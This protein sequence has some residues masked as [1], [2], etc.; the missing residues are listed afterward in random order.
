MSKQIRRKTTLS[1]SISSDLKSR[2]GHRQV[3]V[4]S[5]QEVLHPTM[6]SHQ[7]TDCIHSYGV[8]SSARWLLKVQ[9]PFQFVLKFF[10]VSINLLH[11]KILVQEPVS[12]TEHCTV[13]QIILGHMIA[14]KLIEWPDRKETFLNKS[15]IFNKFTR[16]T[17]FNVFQKNL[18]TKISC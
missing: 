16:K 6:P 13:Q 8:K 10:W 2:L 5:E 4:E 12:V 17:S 11:Q 1:W 18:S 14:I 3:A 15:I 9:S 7:G